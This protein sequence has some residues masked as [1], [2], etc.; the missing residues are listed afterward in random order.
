MIHRLAIVSSLFILTVVAGCSKSKDKPEGG[1]T[2]APAD[3]AAATANS[4]PAKAPA[5]GPTRTAME[6]GEY[7]K[8]ANDAARSANLKMVIEAGSWAGTAAPLQELPAGASLCGGYKMDT[9]S[10]VIIKSPLFG[11]DLKAAYEPIMTKAGCTFEKD[12]TAGNMTNLSWSC[13]KGGA[14]TILTERDTEMYALSS[15]PR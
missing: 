8:R 15:M 5:A 3:P 14:V 13:Q 1:G 6:C 12:A 9:I 10:T 4:E 7:I 2:P 11:S